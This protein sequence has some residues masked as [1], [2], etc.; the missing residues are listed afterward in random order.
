MSSQHLSAR[1]LSDLVNYV[2][3]LPV[4]QRP[5]GEF[6]RREGLNPC[7]VHSWLAKPNRQLEAWT[8][9][10]LGVLPLNHRRPRRPPRCFLNWM[11]AA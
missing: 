9:K 11:R 5:G 10:E 6:V 4:K 7:I 8:E 3:G 1:Q 2:L